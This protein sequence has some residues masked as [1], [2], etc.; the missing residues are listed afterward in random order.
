MPQGSGAIVVHNHLQ[1]SIQGYKVIPY[2]PRLEYL[3]M[4][5]RGIDLKHA[6]IIHTT[7]DH[8]EFFSNKEAPLIITFHNYVLDHFMQQY[9]TLVQKLYYRT[10]LRFFSYQALKRASIVTAVSRYTA[11]LVYKDL[12]FAGDIKIIPNGID[13]RR[14]RPESDREKDSDIR[15]LF[16]GNLTRR[17]GADLLPS[18]VR[19]LNPGIRII[20]T[21][22]LRGKGH[23]L[24]DDR[25]EFIGHIPYEKM[26]SLYQSVHVLL[27]PTVREGFGLA[28]A[29]A[30]S[31]GLPVVA[32]DCSTMP[33][34]I[35]HGQGGYLC[36]LGNVDEF[37][38]HINKL[39]RSPSLRARMGEYNRTR[40]EKEYKHE[41]MIKR[42]RMLFEEVLE[43]D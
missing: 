37:A 43:T 5:L 41:E 26:P 20:C 18:I 14:F 11:E 21:G 40:V 34:L 17:K 35:H 30:M 2:S 6:D 39:A 38:R 8:A 7:P 15:V 28:V 22:G 36:R 31:C 16:S 3:P 42:Y 12:G 9:S 19:Q 1:D 23:S 33:D 27:M 32:T 13:A 29:E 4:L 25:I 24:R 10:S